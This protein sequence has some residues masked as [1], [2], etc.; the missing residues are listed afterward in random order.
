MEFACPSLRA[1]DTGA[2]LSLSDIA[3]DIHINPS[4]LK[5]TIKASK[6]DPFRQ[7]MSIFLASIDLPLCSVSSMTSYLAIRGP[8]PGPLFLW[9]DAS[10]IST[11]TL[12]SESLVDALKFAL[13]RCGFD[14][15]NYK[16]HSFRT[17][18]ATTAAAQVLLTLQ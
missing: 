17:E 9:K 4:T 16:G 7:G 2:H 15:L 11:S 13:T 6:T 10:T 18:A 1:Y 14:T 8:Q 5:H 3:L 12:S